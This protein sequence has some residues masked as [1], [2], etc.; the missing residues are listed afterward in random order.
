MRLTKNFSLHEFECHDGS[1]TPQEIIYNLQK[2][3]IQLQVLRDFLGKPITINSGYR[4]PEYNAS[5]KGSVKNSQHTLGKASDIVV[6]GYTPH[7]LSNVIED[8][9][10]R[11]DMLQGGLGVYKTFIHYDIGYNGK[12][13]RW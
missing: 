7:Q 13:R 10:A 12:R 4:S 11:G 5:I 1:E 2:L 3:A 8:L 6:K 9:I